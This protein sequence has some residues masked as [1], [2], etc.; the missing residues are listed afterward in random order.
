MMRT[1]LFVIAV[2][3]WVLGAAFEWVEDLCRS[4]RSL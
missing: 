3:D 2:V 1:V 4:I